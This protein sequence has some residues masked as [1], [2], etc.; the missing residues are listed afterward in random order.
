MFDLLF[1]SRNLSLLLIKCNIVKPKVRAF[2]IRPED[3]NIFV[4][5]CSLFRAFSVLELLARYEQMPS[6]QSA[7]H[8]LLF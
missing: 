1:N 7:L 5:A 2:V 3:I 8:V 4:F 6:C